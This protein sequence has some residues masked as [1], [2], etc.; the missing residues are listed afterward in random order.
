MCGLQSKYEVVWKV[1]LCVTGASK[2]ATI[3]A[4]VECHAISWAEIAAPSSIDCLEIPAH[5]A[6]RLRLDSDKTEYS[7]RESSFRISDTILCVIVNN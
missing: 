5:S 3:D 4:F 6:M 7:P 2:A 1:A